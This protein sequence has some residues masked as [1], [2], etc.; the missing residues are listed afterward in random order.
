MKRTHL[1]LVDAHPGTSSQLGGHTTLIVPPGAGVRQFVEAAAA[2]G[3]SMETAGR[4]ALERALVLLDIAP[5]GLDLDAARHRLEAAAVGTHPRRPLSPRQASYVRALQ[6][7]RSVR[8]GNVAGGLRI[9]AP[10]RLLTRARE[11]LRPAAFE[12]SAIPEMISWEVAATLEGRAMG[13]WAL[14]VLAA[15]RAVG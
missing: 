13:E 14:T 3:L 9:S 2:A 1:Q 11:V 5:L 4:L 15:A 7:A 8:P 10:E 12:V 6:L